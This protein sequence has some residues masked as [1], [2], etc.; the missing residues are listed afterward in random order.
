MC[1]RFTPHGVRELIK[2]FPYLFGAV[3]ICGFAFRDFTVSVQGVAI[4]EVNCE[5]DLLPFMERRRKRRVL[6]DL[7]TRRKFHNRLVV[8]RIR[9]EDVEVGAAV[10]DDAG[11]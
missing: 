11:D 3:W 2:L 5:I 10:R 4:F 1:K 6:T 7:D 8:E 9:A